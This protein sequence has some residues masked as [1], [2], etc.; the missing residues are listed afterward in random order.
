MSPTAMPKAGKEAKRQSDTFKSS[1]QS[2]TMSRHQTIVALLLSAALP[3]NVCSSSSSSSSSSETKISPPFLQAARRFPF[4]PGSLEGVDVGGVIKD[5]IS[6]EAEGGSRRRRQ[7]SR[8]SACSSPISSTLSLARGGHD[9]G[10]LQ[11]ITSLSQIEQILQSQITSAPT[12][13]PLIVL[14][15]TANNCPP[16][17]MIRPIYEDMSALTEFVDVQFLKVNVNDCPDVAERFDVDGWPT[18]LL[19]RGGKVVDSIVGGMAAKEG[20]YNLVAKHAA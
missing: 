10:T 8:N 1:Q 19:F 18:F 20:L 7:S 5:V 14:Y 3:A 17:Q 12:P 4:I 16:C 6:D 15:F 9:G 13:A 2:G 11:I